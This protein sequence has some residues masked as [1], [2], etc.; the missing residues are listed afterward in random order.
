MAEGYLNVRFSDRFEAFSAGMQKTTVHPLAIEV[1]AEIGI[2]ISGQ[3]SKKLDGFFGQ[4]F[5]TVVT[6]CDPAYGACPIFPEAKRTIHKSFPDPSQF[7]GSMEEMREEF[8][9]VRDKIIRWLDDGFG[10]DSFP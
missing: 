5:D 2:D 3:R 9:R 10:F 6:L 4:P 8:R 7:I 1:M